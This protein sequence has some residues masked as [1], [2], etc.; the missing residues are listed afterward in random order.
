MT[1]L[2]KG[3]DISVGMRA[4]LE[5][6]CMKLTQDDVARIAGVAAIDVSRY[7]RDMLVSAA[8]QAAILNVFRRHEPDDSDALPPLK[9]LVGSAG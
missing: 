5:R 8:K 1:T 6:T 3:L 7:E 9:P 2:D 4:R